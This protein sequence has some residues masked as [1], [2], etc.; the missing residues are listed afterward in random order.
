MSGF[1]L[2]TSG[3]L[4]PVDTAISLVNSGNNAYTASSGNAKT[5]PLLNVTAGHLLVLTVS[6]KAGVTCGVE[7][8]DS[9]AGIGITWAKAIS[10]LY[11]SGTGIF[12]DV[13]IWYGLVTSGGSTSVGW[14]VIN[15]A[16]IPTGFM[17]ISEWS[18]TASSSVLDQTAIEGPDSGTT[19][20]GSDVQTTH[21]GG[22]VVNAIATPSTAFPNVFESGWTNLIGTGND[23]SFIAQVFP[24]IGAT[25]PE[26][27]L[28]SFSEYV[29]CGASF[30]A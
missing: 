23:A 15:A 22:L 7:S 4:A 17:S 29:A 19:V 13:D 6:A 2:M 14:N 21:A 3:L 27:V 16:N 10:N 9:V 1:S 30:N 5:P 20:F 8:I 25:Q 26:Y 18:N 24:G 12:L 28:G 11:N